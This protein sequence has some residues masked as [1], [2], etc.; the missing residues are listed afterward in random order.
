MYDKVAREIIVRTHFGCEIEDIAKTVILTPIWN[1]EGFKAASDKTIKE[2][3]G[4][5]DGITVIYKGVEITV[6]SSRV[7]APMSGDCALA[8]SYTDCESVLFSGSA[9]AINPSYNIGDLLAVKEAVIGEG[10]SRYHREDITKDCFGE[11][12]EGDAAV[13]GTLMEVIKGYS[14]QFGAACRTGRIF[15]I[16]SI[17]GENKETFEYMRQKGCDAVE[18]EVSAIFTAC[19]KAGKKA[20]AL[21]IISD[22]PLKYRNLF[23]GIT[24]EDVEK[25]NGIKTRLPEI[26]MEAAVRLS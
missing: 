16:D 22:L 3:E 18:M 15:S 24:E 23:E 12:V 9:G 1:L 2:F 8:L 21:I 5:Y 7:G 25:Y 6:I 26:I 11:L 20:A 19:K 10:F 14:V 17:L 13:C 4:W